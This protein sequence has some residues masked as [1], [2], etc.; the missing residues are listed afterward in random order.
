VEKRELTLV[1]FCQRTAFNILH[2]LGCLLYCADAFS[3]RGS[4]VETWLAASPGG[5]R[6]RRWARRGKPGLYT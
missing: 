2:S 5:E 1:T 6:D 4:L 3:V